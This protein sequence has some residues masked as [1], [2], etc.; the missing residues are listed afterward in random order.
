MDSERR[1]RRTPAVVQRDAPA[2]IRA[3]SP[4]AEPDYLDLFVLTAD[5]VADRSAEQ[6]AR[7]AF[8]TVAGRTGQAVW[9]GIVGL[10]L[11]H[12]PAPDRVAGWRIAERGDRW[13][14]LAARGWMLTAHVIFHVEDD[15]LSVATVIRY[16]RRIAAA[17]WPPLSARHRLAMPRVLVAAHRARPNAASA[18][19]RAGM[20][21]G[22]A[23]LRLPIGAHTVQP[24]RIH[25]LTPDFRVEDVWA[26]PTVGG[27]GDLRR[28]V[29]QFATG[30]EH[31]SAPTRVLFAARRT[32][33]A[34]AGW[35]RPGTGVG[36][37]VRSL[38]ERLPADLREG[39]PGPDLPR[40]PFRSVYLTD[41]EWAAEVANG[42][43]HAVVHIGWVRAGDGGYRG[44]MAILV[45][46]NG[47]VGRAYMTAIAPF[48]YL[49]VYPALIRSIE[50]AWRPHAAADG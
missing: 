11:S 28:L 18:A 15:R 27:P 7:A 45:K 9:R 35:D 3:L 19:T 33:G 50:R 10:R 21:S 46:P 34:L 2:A 16:D 1:T 38:R 14:R 29:D 41:S 42:T 17:L 31:V 25:D 8:E 37:R 48:R 6:W 12:R 5:G 44:Q 24:W 40:L 47:R 36:T 13:V 49:V 39:P 22:I 23:G 30:I 26:L 43:V 20:P 32:L 4:I